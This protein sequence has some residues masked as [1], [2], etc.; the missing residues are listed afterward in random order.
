MRVSGSINVI[1][2]FFDWVT[3]FVLVQLVWIVLT[4]MGV[5]FF[6]IFPASVAMF[7]IVRKWLTGKDDFPI[8]PYMWKTYKKEFIKSNAYFYTLMGVGTLLYFYFK[9]FQSG[10]GKFEAISTI[11]LFVL[12]LIYCLTLMI[13]FPVY[14]HYELNLKNFYKMIWYITLSYP[15]HMITI[16]VIYALF[17]WMISKIP[18]LIPFMSFNLLAFSVMFIMT[19]VFKKIE[20]KKIL[21]TNDLI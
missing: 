18:G 19:L 11:I 8:I 20:D 10:Y 6:G 7:S 16:L 3:K 9:F 14:A 13:A 4:L 21:Y 15:F 17:V 2:S 1:M 5:G 12:I